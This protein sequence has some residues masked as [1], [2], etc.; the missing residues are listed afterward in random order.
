MPRESKADRAWRKRVEEAT[1]ELLGRE[2]VVRYG[3]EGGEHFCRPDQLLVAREEI[4]RLAAGL[5]ELGAEPADDRAVGGVVQYV[6]PRGTDVHEAVLLLRASRRPGGGPRTATGGVAPNALLFGA[7]KWRG[8]PGRPP[9]PAA[10]LDLARGAEGQGVL[11]AVVDTGQAQESLRLAWVQSQLTVSPADLDL[12]DEDGDGLL[13]L[14]A[15]HGTFVAG[16][17]A[18]VAPG[19]KVLALKAL[20]ASGITDDLTAARRVS[21]ALTAGAQVINL[22]FGG[23]THSDAGLIALDGVLPGRDGKAVVVAAAGNDAVDRPFFPAADPVVVAVAAVGTRRRRAA[24]SNFGPW[25][26]ACAEGDRLL[27]SFV[28]GTAT[29]DSDGDGQRDDFPEPTA[30]WSGTS[31]AAPQVAGALAVR[32]STHGESAVQAVEAL[33]RDPA[34]SRRPNMGVLIRTALRGSPAP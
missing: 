5:R 12:L 28:T 3:P 20:D 24:W 8:C 11:V 22:S 18:Q 6:L 19:A 9:A 1:E 10:G 25:V 34:L 2:D 29:T 26:D 30:F 27:S 16:V 15:G 32:M 14:E 4:D 13:D 7:P 17:V 33:I 31:F 23:Y 21:D